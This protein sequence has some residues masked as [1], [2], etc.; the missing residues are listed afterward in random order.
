MNLL[1]RA[2]QFVVV[3]GLGVGVVVVAGQAVAKKWGPDLRQGWAQATEVFHSIEAKSEQ[4][5]QADRENQLLR[6]KNLALQKEVQE[7]KYKTTARQF[8]AQTVGTSQDLLDR[9]GTPVGRVLASIQYRP[10]GDL[11]P[12]QLLVLAASYLKANEEEKAAVI[13][14]QVTDLD[15][16]SDNSFNTA[17][18]LM[19]AGML[20][21]RLDH[22]VLSESYLQRAL[23]VR[24]GETPEKYHAQARLWLALVNR[25]MK[26]PDQAQVWLRDLVDHHPHSMEAQWVNRPESLSVMNEEEAP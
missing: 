6:R 16:H 11:A 20:W 7:L 18:N 17:R 3:A 15:P 10:P 9:T 2:F 25:R 19:T 8:K 4:L 14:S 13:L 1:K 5:K 21:Y 12:P 26:R 23:K 22:L 24:T